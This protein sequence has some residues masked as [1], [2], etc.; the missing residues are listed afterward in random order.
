MS[1]AD[2][3]FD[4]GLRL[5]QPQA[6]DAAPALPELDLDL[7]LGEL[8]TRPQ[9]AVVGPVGENPLPHLPTQNLNP[10]EN[11]NTQN[12]TCHDTCDQHRTCPDTQCD[13]CPDTQCNTCPVTC[14]DDTCPD[15]QCNTCPVTCDDDTCPDTQCNTCPATC[16][17]DTCDTLCDTCADTCAGH[18]TCVGDTCPEGECDDTNTCFHSCL[19]TCDPACFAPITGPAVSC[20]EFETCHCGVA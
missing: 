19:G 14:D 5:V 8:G 20:P 11:C 10:H 9:L 12:N 15:T 6:V 2:E 1:R 4:L 16:M 7:R 17:G 3:R 13:T 18:L